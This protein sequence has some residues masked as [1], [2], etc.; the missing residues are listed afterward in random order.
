MTEAEDPRHDRSEGPPRHDRSEDPRHD[1]SE[2]PPRHHRSEDPR[3]RECSPRHNRSRQGRVI[4]EMILRDRVIIEV[5]LRI[6]IIE[7]KA[8]IQWRKSA[9]YPPR[10]SRASTS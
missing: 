6:A 2:G 1:R 8:P 3:H 5:I 9:T 10:T 7:M 4:I